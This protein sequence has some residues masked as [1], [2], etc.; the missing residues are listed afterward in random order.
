MS[1]L[2]NDKINFVI[3]KTDL[4]K[5]QIEKTGSLCD[6]NIIVDTKVIECLTE[7]VEIN[8][9]LLD[10]YML[11][12]SNDQNNLKLHENLEEYISKN[13]KSI[14][15]NF[16]LIHDLIKNLTVKIETQVRDLAL[17]KNKIKEFNEIL[18]NYF[19]EKKYIELDDLSAD[20]QELII[21]EIEKKLN[22]KK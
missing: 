5:D 3:D 19:S 16:D 10:L 2:T 21:K 9:N 11:S 7:Q 13:N 15:D 4:L 1:N 8:T 12:N 17:F 14:K 18:I 6:E 20:L 22:E